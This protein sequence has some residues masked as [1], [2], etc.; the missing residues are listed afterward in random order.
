MGHASLSE[1]T[2]HNTNSINPTPDVSSKPDAVCFLK[3]EEIKKPNAK[4]TK[5][6]DAAVPLGD[7]HGVGD[8]GSVP[9]P[10][11]A[12]GDARGALGAPLCAR[13]ERRG[14][15]APALPRGPARPGAPG[16]RRCP[17]H[18]APPAPV[19]AAKC[20]GLDFLPAVSRLFT[21]S[22]RTSRLT[23]ST[24]PFLQASNS[25][26]AG[27]AA[28]T[29]QPGASASAA[30]P[31]AHLRPA[32]AGPGPALPLPPRTAPGARHA[33]PGGRCAR[34]RDPG[35]AAL[36]AGASA[37]SLPA[38]GLIPGRAPPQPQRRSLRGSGVRDTAH[39]ACP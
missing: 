22:G 2:C 11:R 23:R 1:L 7:R 30:A 10:G 19:P 8:T 4:G 14:P 18:P 28:A 12:A 20:S 37:G 3:K 9:G 27:S 24:S 15:S 21:F 16:R 13:T 38:P 39:T 33:L 6:A 29:P 34:R 26:R 25:S 17:P 5:R 31:P 36:C 35:T 32:M